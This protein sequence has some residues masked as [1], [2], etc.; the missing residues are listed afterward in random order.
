MLAQQGEHV[1]LLSLCFVCFGKLFNYK[2]E[3]DE[4]IL[5]LTDLPIQQAIYLFSKSA[6]V[7]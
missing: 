5:H 4:I 1:E 3:R 2:L 6:N 7:P